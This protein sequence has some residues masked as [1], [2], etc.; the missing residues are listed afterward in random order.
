MLTSIVA[1]FSG[2]VTFANG[3]IETF[4]VSCDNDRIWSQNRA[5]SIETFKKV[6]WDYDQVWDN[7]LYWSAIGTKINSS[8]AW[9][10]FSFDTAEVAVPVKITDM[11]C[12]FTCTMTSDTEVYSSLVTIRGTL[13]D[14]LEPGVPSEQ[15]NPE[16]TYDWFGPSFYTQ[17]NIAAYKAKLRNMFAHIIGT[18][19]VN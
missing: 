9:M 2:Q 8:Q 19:A 16:L 13:C 14:G 11:N 7:Y 18:V 10:D 5:E 15:L 12:R 17:Q 4:H 6:S 3:T 1:E